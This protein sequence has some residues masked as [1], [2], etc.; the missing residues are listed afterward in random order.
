M[1]PV[2]VERMIDGVVFRMSVRTPMIGYPIVRYQARRCIQGRD[3]WVT[4][5]ATNSAL[6]VT[7]R[8]AFSA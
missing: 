6:L 7:I 5:P 4:I 2:M 8:D 1:L 3:R